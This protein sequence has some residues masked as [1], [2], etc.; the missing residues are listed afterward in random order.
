[1]DFEMQKYGYSQRVYS[2]NNRIH[3]EYA[4]LL[5]PRAVGYSA[6][7]LNYFFR[8]TIDISVP[9]NGIYSMIDAT[10]P[11]YMPAFTSIQLKATNTTTTGENMTNG[12][13]QLV[14]K[15]K[16]AHADPF[17][18]GFVATDTDFS[19]KVIPEKNNVS[20]L[21]SATP[22]D[23]VFD[24]SQDAIPLWATDLYL[25]VVF[26]GTL[27][28]EENAVAVGFK[29]ISEP[30]PVD[31]FNTTDKICIN[32]SWYEAGSPEAI[33][34]VDTNHDG[35]ADEGDVYGHDPKDI[36]RFFWP[37]SP[38]NY[39]PAS[40]SLYDSRVSDLAPG[41][42]TRAGYLLSDDWFDS[43]SYVHWVKRDPAD[44]WLHEDLR[45]LHLSYSLKRQ[46]DYSEDSALCGGSPPCYIDYY[47][48]ESTTFNDYETPVFYT[49][50]GAMMW[51]GSPQILIFGSY[52]AG[53]Q[54]AY[55]AL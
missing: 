16:V 6:G 17:Q 4:D 48:E 39:R 22:T 25:Q 21:Y 36:Y 40:P 9:S 51:W 46:R 27:G 13:I 28:I 35:I 38:T 44:P 31:I 33:A 34:Q 10:Q 37:Y 19:Y 47:P 3:K 15:Y 8:G 54:C 42:H 43:I 20:A 18:P 45:Y 41:T 29:D 24:L 5:I 30:T 55:E 14:V 2:L 49:F 11:G 23:L 52:P 50:R 32:G 7:L 1:M 12:T 26:K 53:S